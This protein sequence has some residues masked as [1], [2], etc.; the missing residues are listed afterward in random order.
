MHNALVIATCLVLSSMYAKYNSPSLVFVNNQHPPGRHL[1][2]SPA[3]TKL[4]DIN[5]LRHLW[6]RSIRQVHQYHRLTHSF[7]VVNL[8]SLTGSANYELLRQNNRGGEWDC[9][10]AFLSSKRPSAF[11]APLFSISL[12][13]PFI[14]SP[15][16]SITSKRPGGIHR[17]NPTSPFFS[18]KPFRPC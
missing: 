8:P 14:A 9:V 11:L 4:S 3:N 17:P 2:M 15:S 1:L 6:Y 12:Q 18:A 13:T 7:A 5:K 10:F 16:K